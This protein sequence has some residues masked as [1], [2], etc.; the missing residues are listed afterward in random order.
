MAVSVGLY[1]LETVA[2]FLRKKRQEV[3]RMIQEDGLPSVRLPSE[4]REGTAK[5]SATQLTAWLNKHGQRWTVE[6]LIG[7][8]D[9]CQASE[10]DPLIV[11]RLGLVSELRTLCEAAERSLRAGRNCPRTVKAIGQAVAELQGEGEAA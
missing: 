6:E 7:E 4:K 8:L 9:R 3:L 11:S 1:P 10:P 2:C 5:F